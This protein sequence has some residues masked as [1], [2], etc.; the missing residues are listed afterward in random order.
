[1]IGSGIFVLPGLGFKLAGP[2]II[3][4]YTLAGLI[5]LPSALSKAEMATAMP[6][7]GGTYLFIDRSMGPLYGTIAGIG[8]W[9]SLVFKSA[10]ALVGLG[11]YLLILINIPSNMLILVALALAIILL[12]INMVGVKQTGQIQAIIVTLVLFALAAFILDGATFVNQSHYHPFLT[13]GVKGVLK[14]T[15]FVFVSYAGVTKIAS[16]AEEVEK[17]G[18]NI[19]IAILSSVVLMMA[20]YS[21][22]VF[23]IVG[24]SPTDSLMT[25]LTP[26]ALATEQFLGAIGKTIIAIIA[27]LALFSMANAGVLSSTRYPLALSRDK[28]APKQLSQINERFTTPI[29]SILFTGALLLLLITFV[30]VFELAKL[31]SAFQILVF[32][33]INVALIAFRESD[34]ESYQPEFVAPLY[35]WAQIFGIIG[36]LALLTQMGLV[37]IIGASSLIV[38]G[39]VWYRIFGREKTEREGAAVSAI[40]RRHKEYSVKQTESLF[41]TGGKGGI[42]VPTNDET[43]ISEMEAM[44]K[45]AK[46]M[47]TR[48][49]GQLELVKFEDVPDQVTLSS[50]LGSE[51]NEDEFD[52]L[53]TDLQEKHGMTDFRMSANT[54]VSH[55][56]KKSIIN[57]SREKELNLMIAPYDTGRY[58]GEL[59]G[60]D[61][62]YFMN[63]ST[64]DIIFAKLDEPLENVNRITV[65]GHRGPYTALELSVVEAVSQSFSADIHLLHVAHPD[66]KEYHYESIE[67]YHEELE[68]LLGPTTTHEIIRSENYQEICDIANKNTDLVIASTSAKHILYDVIFGTLPDEIIKHSA[69][70]VLL[71]QQHEPRRHTFLRY[72]IEKITQE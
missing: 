64:S 63:K 12:L 60:N 55:D 42:L 11:A 56:L 68:E 67:N 40:R 16:I 38:V 13:H 27:V 43:E 23:V 9:F 5:V 51:V 45:L 29:Y 47:L 31:A 57:Y 32:T 28:L 15:G 72:L 7:S 19:P 59:F 6:E 24:V 69:C 35:P 18:K 52:R 37:S 41:Q 17:P 71:V 44:L 3:L 46:A 25:S 30:P 66:I 70:P 21:L 54:I 14:A 61:V 36:S 49:G 1:M 20:I 26:M 53:I 8:A 22:V 4:A 65:I 10:F 34:L 2:G 48:R 50:A 33:G 62:D 58:H 39:V